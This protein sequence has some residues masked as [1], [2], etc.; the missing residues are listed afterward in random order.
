MNKTHEQ[1]VAQSI[2]K[3]VMQGIALNRV[4]GYHFT[5]NFFGT[6]F[7]K[8]DADDTL[9]NMTP[10]PHSI[11]VDGGLSLGG[12][13]LL[14]DIAMATTIRAGR[15]PAQRLVTARMHLEFTGAVAASTVVAASRYRGRFASG[16]GQQHLSEIS[17]SQGNELIC[18]GSGAF[19]AV[20]VPPGMPALA[21]FPLRRTDDALSRSL[22]Y[23]E[24]TDDERKIYDR[25]EGLLKNHDCKAGDFVHAFLGFTAEPVSS[26]ARAELL[27]GPHVAN[28]VGHLQGG[29]QIALA[30]LTANAAVAGRWKLHSITGT[31]IR[32]GISDRFVADSTIVHEGRLTAVIRTRISGAEKLI[33]ESLST[34]SR[35]P[36]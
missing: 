29:L 9:V 31:F 30:G 24:L 25:A 19:L 34:H 13:A 7:D 26:G 27:N 33:F 2:L 12:I 35:L 5:G 20:P 28:R 32:P 36:D 10:G 16:V 11:T 22:H 8:V 23:V 15:D 1:N 21:P 18:Y 4:P 3:E 17:I 14:A 6:T